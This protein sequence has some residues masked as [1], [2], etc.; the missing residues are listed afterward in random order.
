M[1]T[2]LGFLRFV[3]DLDIELVLAQPS[4]QSEMLTG[5]LIDARILALTSTQVLNSPTAK[6]VD[7]TQRR[8]TLSEDGLSLT[9]EF[10]MAAVGE[11]MQRHLLS[12][13]SRA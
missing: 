11:Q 13:V 4:G 9:T 12:V 5:T 2:E 3:G 6:T 1:H 8:F 10:S 7:A